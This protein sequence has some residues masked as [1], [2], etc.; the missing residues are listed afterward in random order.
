VHYYHRTTCALDALE[1][2]RFENTSEE[3]QTIGPATEK[4]QRSDGISIE[5]KT[6]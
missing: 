1:Q 3:F 4:A 6:Q 5:P 2:I